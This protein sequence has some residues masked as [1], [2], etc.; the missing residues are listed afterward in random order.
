[1]KP[2]IDLGEFVSG[3][4]A[5]SDDLLGIANTA[6]LAIETAQKAGKGSPRSVRE[7]FRALHTIK[8]LSSMVGVEPVVALAHQMESLLRRADQGPP[9][10][11]EAID[12]LLQGV[13]AIEQRVRALREGKPVPEAPVP[14]VQRLEA[15]DSGPLGGTAAPP[16]EFDLE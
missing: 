7:A 13:R 10:G 12:A 9:L 2:K 14:L 6:L 8:G 5:E 16:A 1:M 15:M 4:L 11:A 3:F